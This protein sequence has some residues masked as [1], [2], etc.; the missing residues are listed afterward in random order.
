MSKTQEIKKE[1]TNFRDITQTSDLISY[2]DDK[3]ARLDNIKYLYHYT[4]LESAIRIIQSQRWLL[5]RAADMNDQNEY[6]NGDEKRWRNLFFTSFMR[7]DK[8]SIGMWSMYAQPWS[9]GVKIS[10]PKAAF[11]KW[12]RDTKI[13]NEVVWSD[14]E[15]ASGYMPTGRSVKI[16]NKDTRTLRIS[17]V[18]YSNTESCE[19][20]AR[21]EEKLIC[22]GAT[23]TKLKNAVRLPELTGYVKDMAWSYE[24]EVRIKAEFDNTENFR[25]VA[26]DIPDYV[27]SEMII[28]AS[29]LFEGNLRE[30]LEE[31]ISRVMKTSA[32]LYEGK[33]KIKD[34]CERCEYKNR[35]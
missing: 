4:T 22:G 2:L 9:E 11:T 17:T 21:M 32:S 24:K 15:V 20:S 19:S 18:A 3:T 8:E 6:K 5:T 33:L 10:I 1:I 29:P 26:I 27:I 30:K 34:S 12:I 13:I 28:T 14:E 7:E 35:Y 16:D 23:N 25:R 31:K